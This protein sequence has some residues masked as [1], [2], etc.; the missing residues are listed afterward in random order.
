MRC[1]LLK[2]CG[3]FFACGFAILVGC[4][5]P[6]VGASHDGKGDLSVVRE[7]TYPVIRETFMDN[8]EGVRT[9]IGA[10]KYSKF[11]EHLTTHFALTSLQLTENGDVVSFST[12][13]ALPE[14]LT[15]QENLRFKWVSFDSVGRM[16]G[17]ELAE[18]D[19]TD[20]CKAKLITI[21]GNPPTYAWICSRTVTV[22]VSPKYCV[23]SYI[24]DPETG[25]TTIT[26]DC[27]AAP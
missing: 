18:D 14:E 2:M 24:T 3:S 8:D 11:A 4:G 10:R 15:N 22:C 5:S 7:P 27:L 1:N 16:I 25:T 19:S 12:A 20:G 9:S 6:Q 17:Y 21:P 13:F 23:L 26:C